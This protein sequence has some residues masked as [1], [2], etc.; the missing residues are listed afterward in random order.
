VSNAA[1]PSPFSHSGIR[2]SYLR[3]PYPRLVF[4]AGL[5]ALNPTFFT[6]HRTARPLFACL[7]TRGGS[8]LTCFALHARLFLI[9][10]PLVHDRLRLCLYPHLF[11][12]HL[13]HSEF[14]QLALPSPLNNSRGPPSISVH[15]R[16]VSSFQNF[17][18]LWLS[19]P[20]YFISSHGSPFLCLRP[21][22]EF[23]S[24]PFPVAVKQPLSLLDSR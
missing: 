4:A 12:C 13:I 10:C 24:F 20:A 23:F 11:Q 17:F 2:L 22:P 3:E 14:R 8:N 18:S 6:Q 19:S 5:C 15:G 9:N 7:S 1:F 16:N 21:P